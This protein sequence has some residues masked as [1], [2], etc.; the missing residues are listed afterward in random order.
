MSVSFRVCSL[1]LDVR[2]SLTKIHLNLISP[3][4]ITKGFTTGAVEVE[5]LMKF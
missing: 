4:V 5:Q 1:A 2:I 3:D